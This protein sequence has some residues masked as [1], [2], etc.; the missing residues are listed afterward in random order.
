MPASRITPAALG[1]AV[2]GFRTERGISQEALA[3]AAQIHVTYLSG[4]ERG[5]RNPTLDKLN[6]LAEALGIHTLELL[7]RADAITDA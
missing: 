4:I 3:D 5:L 1:A 6:A 7:A 2:R